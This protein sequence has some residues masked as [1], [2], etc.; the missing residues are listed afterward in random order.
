MLRACRRGG[1]RRPAGAPVKTLIK[2][3]RIMAFSGAC[4][5]LLVRAPRAALGLAVS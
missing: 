1:A 2:V 5:G 4:A 3:V